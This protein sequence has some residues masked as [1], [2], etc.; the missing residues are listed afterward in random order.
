MDYIITDIP[1]DQIIKIKH[2]PVGKFGRYLFN[3]QRL[4]QRLLLVKLH[5]EWMKDETK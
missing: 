4:F 3:G 1:K 2:P 5:T